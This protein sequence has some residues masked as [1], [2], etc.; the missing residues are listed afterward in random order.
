METIPHI[1]NPL[2]AAAPAPAPAP[3]V[4]PA[5]PMIPHCIPNLQY[6]GGA[7]NDPT[8]EQFVRGLHASTEINGI[9]AL[10]GGNAY[11]FDQCHPSAKRGH[12]MFVRP[13]Y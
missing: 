12:R 3:V 11:L 1:Y 2:G 6:V 5:A 4:A 7:D 9:L 8:F 10:A 13:C